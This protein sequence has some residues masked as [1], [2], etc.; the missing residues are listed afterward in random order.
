MYGSGQEAYVRDYSR[1]APSWSAADWLLNKEY[2]FILL[3]GVEYSFGH[4][5]LNVIN[6]PVGRI[7][8][9]RESYDLINYGHNNRALVFLNHMAEWNRF[10]Q[11]VY[12]DQYLKNIDGLEVMNGFAARENISGYNPYGLSGIAEGLWDGC[13]NSG[14]RIWGTANDDAHNLG[15]YGIDYATAGC[16]WNMIWAKELTRSAVIEAIKAGAFYASC[17]I[18]ISDV[19]VGEDSIKVSSPNATHIRVVGDHNRILM[20]VN[21]STATY[22]MRGDEEWIRIVLWNDTIVYPNERSKFPK[23]AWLQP[24]MVGRLLTEN[25]K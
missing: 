1:P 4:P 17:G 22:L 14:L 25:G 9:P 8:R 6:H 19:N 3:N 23:R 18:T 7:S 13:L 20:E 24:I 2:R 12:N 10:P 16:C 5:H 15:Q 11:R 21:D